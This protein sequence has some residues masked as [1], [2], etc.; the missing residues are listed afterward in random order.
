MLSCYGKVDGEEGRTNSAHR[1]V[2]GSWGWNSDVHC[3]NREPILSEDSAKCILHAEKRF[4]GSEHCF[5]LTFETNRYRWK[6]GPLG[7]PFLR[8]VCLT[9]FFFIIN[10][11]QISSIIASTVYCAQIRFNK[12]KKKKVKLHATRYTIA[13]PYD[14]HPSVSQLSRVSRSLLL[15]HDLKLDIDSTCP[16]SPA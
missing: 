15:I 8:L 4:L 14:A 2:V 13:Y 5:R 6:D 1:R 12:K 16:R 3:Q 7:L 9:Q 11:Y 10:I